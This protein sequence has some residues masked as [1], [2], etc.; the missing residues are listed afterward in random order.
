MQKQIVWSAT[1][2]MVLA[3]SAAQ[4]QEKRAELG[5]N[6]GYT[7]SEGVTATDVVAGA[8]FDTGIDPK[9]SFSWNLDFGYFVTEK[10]E[11]GALFAQQNSQMEFFA[12]TG[13]FRTIPQNWNV[14]NFQG[15]VAYNTGTFESK[16]RVY[17]LG[18]LGFTRYTSQDFQGPNALPFEIRGASKFASTWGAGVK[19]Y[20]APA[21]GMKLGLRWTPTALGSLTDDWLCGPYGGCEVVEVNRSWSRQLEFTTGGFLRF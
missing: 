16:T 17:F 7:G 9:S 2:I 5:F 6:L 18:G 21:F 15:T 11:V 14:N 12:Q 8:R 10:V 4:A 13:A 19:F 1:L 3:T 20:P